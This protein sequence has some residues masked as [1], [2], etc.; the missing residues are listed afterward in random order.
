MIIRSLALAMLA[1]ASSPSVAG[2]VPESGRKDARMRIVSY[3]HGQVTKLSTVAGTALVITF[4]RS[5]RIT[6]VAVTDSKN[7]AAMPR[8]NFLF[9]KPRDVLPSQPAIVLTSGPKGVRRYVFEIEAISATRQAAERR[10]VYYS[11]EFKYPDDE[12]AAKLAAARYQRQRQLARAKETRARA[13]LI[14]ASTPSPIRAKN[15]RY[16]AKGNRSLMPVAIFDNG[17]ST[18]FQFRSD[19]RMPAIF[20]I[21]P[22]GRDAVV[23][24]SIKRGYVVVGIVAES[25]RLRDGRISL[26]IWNR[27]SSSGQYAAVID[28]RAVSRNSKD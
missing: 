28:R 20:R 25:W 10:D 24:T 26:R 13:L 23:N 8:E 27:G 15:W 6:A 1:L 18:F 12:M 3:D 21:T 11:V 5:E 2:Q 16:V 9:L 19:A 22:D 4:A 14:R 17:S 7:L